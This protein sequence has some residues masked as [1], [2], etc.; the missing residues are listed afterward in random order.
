VRGMRKSLRFKSTIVS[1]R[2][3]RPS[4][5]T[6]EGGLRSRESGRKGGKNLCRGGT[7]PGEKVSK[8]EKR[9]EETLL[10][11]IFR[12]GSART[13]LWRGKILSGGRYVTLLPCVA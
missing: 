2:K 11:F 6:F 1:D 9:K 5:L 12:E 10:C 4:S 8:R 3:R 7:E 13:R